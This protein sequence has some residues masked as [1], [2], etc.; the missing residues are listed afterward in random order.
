MPSC[1]THVESTNR[2]FSFFAHRYRRRFEKK[3]F[4]SSQ[5]QLIEG[6]KLAGIEGASILEI[7]CGVGH[8]H[9]S[10][11]EAGANKAAGIDIAAGMLN[12]ARRWAVDRGLDQRTSYLEG[13]FVAVS[14]R[15]DSADI[16]ILDKVVCCYP[17]AD[18]LVHASLAKT[19]RIY[20]LTYPR[21]RWFIRAIWG[22]TTMLMAL[23]RIGYRSYIHDPG[24][25][26]GWIEAA[27]FKKTYENTTIMWLTQVYVRE[28]DACRTDFDQA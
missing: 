21:S 24:M 5:Q 9:Q 19:G 27:G 26:E 2:L 8:L 28:L 4:E 23:V 6:I 1:C 3:G 10:L 22:L 25:I 17:D 11:L 14:D 16:T 7:G 13:D 18:R 15:V 12:E 20:A